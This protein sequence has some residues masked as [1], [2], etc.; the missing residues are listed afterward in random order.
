MNRRD[1][2]IL[3]STAIAWPQ[4]VRAQQKTMRAIGFLSGT[5]SV[6]YAP[7][8][9]AFRE[10]LAEAG[11]VE[12]QKV[13]IEYRWAD[14]VFDRLPEMAEDLVHRK[15][16]LIVT[17]G[18]TLAAM[19]ARGAT[20]TIP[21]VFIAGDDSV[22]TG[23]VA[24]LARPGGRTGISFLVVDLNAKRLELLSELVPQAKTMGLLVNLGNSTKVQLIVLNTSAE[25]EIDAAFGTFGERHVKALLI[26]NDAFF[27][28]QRE[29][30]IA[31]AARYRIPASYEAGESVRAGGLMSYGANIQAMYRQLGIYTAKV[32]KG[33]KPADLPVE[34]PTKF[35]PAINLKTAKALGL[36]VPRSLLVAADE[37]TE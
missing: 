35:E 1:L 24:S 28:S 8:V 3:G 36:I 4:I 21:T 5:S 18:G 23:L 11:F 14:G 34:Q 32:L 9:A 25:G 15:V 29:R 12:G 16:D 6:R 30:L 13:T 17:S 37:V 2:L 31:L 7:F 20:D 22:A 10:A 26:G 19:A 33:T 27:N